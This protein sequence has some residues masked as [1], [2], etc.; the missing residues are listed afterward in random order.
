IGLRVAAILCIGIAVEGAYRLAWLW[1]R[2][3]WGAAAAALVYGLNGAVS[4]NTA[5]GYII[6]M[7]YGSLPWMAYHAFRIREG[8]TQ[9]IWLGFWA[10]FAAI[11]GLQY[12][13][14][15]A[16]FLTAAIWLRA[17]RVRPSASLP[18][19]AAAGSFLALSG[20]RSATML[21]VLLR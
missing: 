13:T 15:Y 3:P 20:W 11:N 21:P 1:L 16:V 6:A 17:V 7:S 5:D 14:I 10:A 12:L 2:E 18:T 19:L 9:G 4:V 8:G